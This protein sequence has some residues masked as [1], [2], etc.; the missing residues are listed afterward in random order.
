MQPGLGDDRVMM[1]TQL[2]LKR[3]DGSGESSHR[4]P[5]DRGHRFGR[6]PC[7]FGEDPYLVE[8]RVRGIG[9]E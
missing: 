6:I 8:V 1:V 5:R 3:R 7:P 9:A 4:S 2:I